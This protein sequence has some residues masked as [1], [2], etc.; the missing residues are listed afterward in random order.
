MGAQNK[1]RREGV[2]KGEI[3]TAV[4]SNPKNL[5]SNP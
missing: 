2:G 4:E 5:P 1:E 3:S